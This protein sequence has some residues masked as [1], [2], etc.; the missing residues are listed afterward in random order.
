MKRVSE[1][2]DDLVVEIPLVVGM[3]VERVQA[4]N[5]IIVPIDVPDPRDL[6]GV[7]SV[8]TLICATAP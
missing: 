3:G 4:P 6:V 1:T 8:Q 2:E 7:G 5:T